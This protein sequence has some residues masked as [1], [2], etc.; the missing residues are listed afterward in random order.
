MIEKK[1]QS[2]EKV[3][4]VAVVHFGKET[5]EK[6][7]E[8]LEELHLLTNTAGGTVQKRFIQKINIVNPKTYI[9]A[10][11][12][13]EIT[14]Y[15][16][17]NKI[18]SL[19]FDDQLT[20]S[21]QRNIEKIV[22]CK[23]LDRTQLILDIFAQRATTSYAKTQV[24]LAQYQYLLPRL[25]GMWTHLEKQKGG[26]GMK[27]PGETEIETDRRLVKGRI[28]LL[29]KKLATIDRQMIT[30]RNNRGKYIQVSL[31]GY[32]NAGKTSLLNIL[33][34][35]DKLAENK[36][37]ATLDPTIRK[38]TL[39]NKTF[40]LADTVGFIRK[41]PT[42]LVESFKSTLDELKNADIL[43][44]VI[45]LSNESFMEQIDAVNLILGSL[46]LE[47]KP[48]LYIFNKIDAYTFVKKDEWDLSSVEL[49]NN[50][51]EEMKSYLKNKFKDT[52]FIS[53]LHK[54]DLLSF[55]EE[56]YKKIS[57]IYQIKYPYMHDVFPLY[58]EDG[59][60]L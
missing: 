2:H 5:E 39:Q 10:G 46:K 32:T 51:L 54:T 50:T 57:E 9:G 6:V 18:D 19:I 52:F 37:F 42:E 7:L 45:D 20:P 55:K 38:T 14:D 44:H 40:L 30:Q 28:S 22:N 47:D 53:A 3:V 36:L 56:L 41:L 15:I 34:K 11:K 59:T 31:V 24:E 8:Y 1:T 16:K 21:Q 43:L 58:K 35:S 48:I 13:E 25:V 4:L 60:P 17:E 26:I 12:L 23:V 29:K 33:S 27:G 49:E